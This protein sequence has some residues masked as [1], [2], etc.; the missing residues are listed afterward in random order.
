MTLN[1]LGHDL[2]RPLI[3]LLEKKI[4]LRSTTSYCQVKYKKTRH[5]L[6][7]EFLEPELEQ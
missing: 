4:R 7:N 5:F 1:D 6:A 2:Q 3:D